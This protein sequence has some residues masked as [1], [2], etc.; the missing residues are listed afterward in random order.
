MA[1]F[2]AQLE[3][4][5]WRECLMAIIFDNAMVWSFNQKERTFNETTQRW[6]YGDWVP[7]EESLKFCEDGVSIK[8][9]EY[10]P[11]KDMTHPLYNK[12]YF[13]TVR[14]VE[15]VQGMVFCDEDNKQIRPHFDGAIL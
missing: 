10:F 7:P 8:M 13:W 15:N 6:E 4:H 11:V 9:K 12:A 1:E 5:N 3:E 14:H 2:Q